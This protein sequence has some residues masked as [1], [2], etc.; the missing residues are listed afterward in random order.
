MVCSGSTAPS[1]RYTRL[2]RHHMMP[3]SCEPACRP[4]H[5]HTVVCCA[6]GVRLANSSLVLRKPA[7]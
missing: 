4:L 6:A 1:P 5:L 2:Q 7:W 3:S